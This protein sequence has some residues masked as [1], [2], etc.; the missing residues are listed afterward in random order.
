MSV[1]AQGCTKCVF[2]AAMSPTLYTIGYERQ[3]IGEYVDALVS[4]DV[5]VVLDVRQTAWSHRRDFSKSALEHTLAAVGISYMHADFAGNPKEIR[6]SA[7]TYA[8]CL[9]SYAAYLDTA[10][11]VDE[12]L[13]AVLSDLFA[14]GNAVCLTCYERHPGDC[15]RGILAHRWAE[16]CRGHVEHLS[17]GGLPRRAPEFILS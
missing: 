15:H 10:G 2:I 5:T 9:S 1:L 16:R 6:A 4:A 14:T 13:E 8:E 17:P 7:R 11:Y 3:S 12:F